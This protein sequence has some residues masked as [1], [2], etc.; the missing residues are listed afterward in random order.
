MVP[1]GGDYLVPSEQGRTL[2]I[3]H[4]LNCCQPRV[5]FCASSPIRSRTAPAT[6]CSKAPPA[7][8]TLSLQGKVGDPLTGHR[9]SCPTP[10]MPAQHSPTLAVK[11]LGSVGDIELLIPLGGINPLPLGSLVGCWL[12]PLPTHNLC[13]NTLPGRAPVS[14]CGLGEPCQCPGPGLPCLPA[15]RQCFLQDPVSLCTHVSPAL[16]SRAGKKGKVAAGAEE[17]MF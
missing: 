12:W 6:C 17:A 8:P 3:A 13:E 10:Q 16:D 14:P 1:S 15:S 5:R 2:S 7:P 9:P 11:I 4:H